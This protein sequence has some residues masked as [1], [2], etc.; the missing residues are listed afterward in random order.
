[1]HC[2]HLTF[3]GSTQYC[4]EKSWIIHFHIHLIPL[5]L[6]LKTLDYSTVDPSIQCHYEAHQWITPPLHFTPPLPPPVPPSSDLTSSHASVPSRPLFP[7]GQPA[8]WVLPMYCTLSREWDHPTPMYNAWG[9][10]V[11]TVHRVQEFQHVQRPGKVVVILS[12]ISESV[13]KTV[14]I[15]VVI[16]E[17]A[18][19]GIF[20]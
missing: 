18:L 15:M 1:M 8:W 7:P 11:W 3:T 6:D 14:V 19:I 20:Q 17:S 10:A 13:Q 2:I 12:M 5:L 9:Y 16:S 4:I